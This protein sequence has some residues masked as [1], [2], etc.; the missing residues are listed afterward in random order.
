LN[1]E[2]VLKV[3]AI[4]LA[5]GTGS[6]FGG[7][8]PKQF[9][10]IGERT[11][12]EHSVAAFDDHP[13]IDEIVIVIHPDHVDRTEKMMNSFSKVKAIIPGGQ[14]RS[15]SSFAG[16]EFFNE[17]QPDTKIL[18]HDAARPFVSG[19]IISNVIKALDS[20]K[21]VNV[22]VS[23]PDTVIETDRTGKMKNIPQRSSLKLVQT[24]QGF[25]LSVIAKAYETA[26][27]DPAFIATDDCGVVFNYLK[28]IDIFIIEGEKRNMK[29]TER[30]DIFIIQ[31]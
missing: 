21:A 24:P 31:N 13:Q 18:I 19:D 2:A 27:K 17:Y 20:H 9:E 14:T 5:G 22:A 15:L 11:I 6:R 12:I 16:I 4:I 10:K 8:L 3:V 26:F 28:D 29:I 1:K 23:I 7:D 30:S 25:I